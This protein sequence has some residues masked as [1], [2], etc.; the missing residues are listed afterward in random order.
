M[1]SRCRRSRRLASRRRR[2]L[3]PGAGTRQR[4]VAALLAGFAYMVHS[5]GLVLLAGSAAVGR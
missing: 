1:R 2:V 4:P 3:P 5:R